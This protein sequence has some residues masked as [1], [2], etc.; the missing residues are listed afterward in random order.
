KF[1]EWDT[2]PLI[3]FRPIVEPKVPGAFISQDPIE[4]I[5]SGQFSQIPW[6]TGIN[7]EDGA[8]RTVPIYSKPSLIQEL[9]D[10]FDKI[11]PITL[12]YGRTSED[13]EYI[14]KKVREYYFGDRQIDNSTKDEVTKMYTD[15]W[16]LLGAHEAIKLHLKYGNQPI[17]YY[18]FGYRGVIS[19]S[20]AFGDPVNDYGAIHVDELLYLFPIQ[21]GPEK[22][23]DE[24]DRR[25]ER[26]MT[27][28]WTNFAKTGD[29]TPELN[30]LIQSKW[31]PTSSSK[32]EYYFLHEPDKSEMR[33]G[34]YLERVKFLKGLPLDPRLTEIVKD[35][36]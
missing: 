23:R 5:K 6:L 33:E 27:T 21:F 22:V 32:M 25:E 2:D 35:E 9:N 3:P 19:F 28:I 16:F 17:Y 30:E 15:N 13:V 11:A 8:L 24:R 14:T 36:L 34:L 20:A 7:T 12:F 1:Q 31:T 4:I 18:L 10:D 29:P 26:F